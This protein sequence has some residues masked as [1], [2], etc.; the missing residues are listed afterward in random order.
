MLIFGVYTNFM[1]TRISSLP[2]EKD[3]TE[4]P[5]PQKKRSLLESGVNLMSTIV[6]LILSAVA[7]FI[8]MWI[9]IKQ[10]DYDKLKNKP[11]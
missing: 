9:N 6:S 5:V 1:N 2:L 3:T 8:F 11:K 4:T 7:A 10:R